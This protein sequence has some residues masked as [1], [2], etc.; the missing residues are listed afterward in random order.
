MGAALCKSSYIT[1]IQFLLEFSPLLDSS[2]LLLQNN[3]ISRNFHKYR[4]RSTL[5]ALMN[6]WLNEHR[7]K[8]V[9][10]ARRAKNGKNSAK[11]IACTSG[12][13]IN[14]TYFEVLWKYK[15]ILLHIHMYLKHDLFAFLLEYFF[16][17]ALL[18]NRC[19][20]QTVYGSLFSDFS[21]LC[22]CTIR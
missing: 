1:L 11:I 14:H 17:Q 12:C 22:N 5:A 20:F 3:L 15:Q 9:C 7:A 21:P 10:N 2:D 13:T 18:Q 4:K 16:N 6:Q 19:V 8:Y